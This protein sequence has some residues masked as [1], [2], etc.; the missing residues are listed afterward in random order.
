MRKGFNIERVRLDTLNT[1]W[2]LQVRRVYIG[3]MFIGRDQRPLF[4]LKWLESLPRVGFTQPIVRV[5]R[6][7]VDRPSLL[8][9]PVESHA[10]T[11]SS[12]EVE[13]SLDDMARCADAKVWTCHMNTCNKKAKKLIGRFDEILQLADGGASQPELELRARNQK[14]TP[15]VLLLRCYLCAKAR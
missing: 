6:S 9:A 10:E 12:S 14:P 4:S 7:S 5:S 1:D 3:G 15:S 11:T 2:M 8:T 13:Q